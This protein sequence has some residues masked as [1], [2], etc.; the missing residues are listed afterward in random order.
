MTSTTY[1]VVS[2]S[3]DHIRSGL[4]AIDAMDEILSHDGYAYEIRREADGS[5]FT[6]WHSDGS[7]ASPRGARHM[8][9]TVIYSV[10]NNA[11]AAKAEIAA[12]VLAASEGWPGSPEAMTDAE[13]DA[14]IGDRTMTKSEATSAMQNGTKIEAGINEDHDTGRIVSIDG[15]MAMIAWDSGVRTV[16]PISDLSVADDA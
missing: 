12:K 2:E 16:C 14:S 6:L 11:D 8:V 10:A 13:Y 5:G 1:T 7:A 3:G 15:N 9:Q 4:T